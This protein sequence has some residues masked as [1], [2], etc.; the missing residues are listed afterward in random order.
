[1]IFFVS[2]M[3]DSAA[4]VYSRP[5]FDVSRGVAVRNFSDEI[6]R[7]AAD[8]QLFAHPEDFHLYELGTYDDAVAM[9]VTTGPPALICR[10]VDF[11]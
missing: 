7:S 2:V 1:M 6:K 5:M 4:G 10:A 3:Y 9:L 8:N 11:K